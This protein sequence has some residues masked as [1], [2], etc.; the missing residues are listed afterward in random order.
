MSNKMDQLCEEKNQ[1]AKPVMVTL[2]AHSNE[3]VLQ[4]YTSTTASHA[5]CHNQLKGDRTRKSCRWEE[6]Q[7]WESSKTSPN[8]YSSCN[9]YGNQWGEGT[10]T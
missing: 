1:K 3:F 5:L 7:G 9:L 10:E 4:R 2:W 8:L 6:N